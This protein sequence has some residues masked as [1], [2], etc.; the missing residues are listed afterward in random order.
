[1][2]GIAGVVPNN[3][4]FASFVI[5]EWLPWMTE[6]VILHASGV[7]I[8]EL[9]MKFGKSDNHLR[10]IM[11]TQQAKE[12]LVRISRT[13][14]ASAS[15]ELSDKLAAA[16]ILAVD[17][18]VDA[19]SDDSLKQA[20]PFD[21]WDASRK[22]L[23]TIERMTSPQPVHHTQVTQ[24]ILNVTPDMLERLRNAPTMNTLSEVHHVDYLGSPPPSGVNEE[25]V[26]RRRISEVTGES[27]DGPSVPLSGRPIL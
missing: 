15:S 8:P 5:K 14:I 16:K 12:I 4:A 13:A 7:S 2:A 23:E 3:S 19:L 27:E 18:I 25:G 1:M 22:S 24:N 10:N 26:Q 6:A 17:N 20:K 11:N 9:R 21:F